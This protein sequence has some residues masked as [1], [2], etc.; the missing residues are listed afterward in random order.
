M[1]S[2]LGPW[3]LPTKSKKCIALDAYSVSSLAH[4]PY[5]FPHRFDVMVVVHEVK[6]WRVASKIGRSW[7]ANLLNLLAGWFPVDWRCVRYWYWFWC[8][9]PDLARWLRYWG[10]VL[11]APCGAP[12]TLARRYGYGTGA[13]SHPW[14]GGAIN[15]GIDDRIVWCFVWRN[16]M[17]GRSYR[18]PFSWS[19]TT[20]STRPRVAYRSKT[21]SGPPLQH[22]G[23]IN[24][25][26][27]VACVLVLFRR[28]KGR[29]EVSS[30]ISAVILWYSVRESNARTSRLWAWRTTL[31]LT[32][33]WTQ[34][35]TILERSELWCC[36]QLSRNMVELNCLG[37]Y[38]AK[39]PIFTVV[40]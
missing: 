2:A 11:E 28:W 16:V 35:M 22:R 1:G 23:T 19:S 30:T 5:A 15:G 12:G 38:L 20:I 33:C 26:P 10:G 37:C 31:V 9:R 18:A 32:M 14:K 6:W 40:R 3:Q 24:G 13:K 34:Y 29:E 25:A 4:A 7:Q 17:T 8:A 39:K 36:Y 21:A 27:H